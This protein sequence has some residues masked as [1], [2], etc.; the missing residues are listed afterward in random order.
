MKIVAALGGNM[1]SDSSNSSETFEDQLE[2][3]KTSAAILCD[4]IDL[5]HDLIITHGNGPQVGSLL[6]QQQ[7]DVEGSVELPLNILGAMTQGQI[8]VLLQHEMINQLRARSLDN[9]VVVIPTTVLVDKDDQGFKDPSKP[10]GPYFGEERLQQFL[11]EYPEFSYIETDKGFRRVVASPTPLT[12][13]EGDVIAKLSE[14]NLVIAVGGGGTPVTNGNN[15]IVRKDAVIDK[16]L[17]SSVL[18]NHLD[19]DVL[20]ILTNV[21]GVYK[22][23]NKAEQEFLTEVNQREAQ[24]LI[25]SGQVSKGSMEPKVRAGLHFNGN[26]SIIT[27]PENAVEALKGKAGTRITSN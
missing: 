11:D 23:F 2:R 18:A 3:I 5:G 20:M 6:L 25:E 1:I 21:E 12:I 7:A 27:S 13:L 16:D 15:K 22:N 10:V 26:Y 19:A 14:T 9:Q 24:Q 8:G 17:A 4:I